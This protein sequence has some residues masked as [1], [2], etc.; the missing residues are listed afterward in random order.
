MNR[1]IYETHEVL[2]RR[3]GPSFEGWQAALVSAGENERFIWKRD[4]DPNA[5]E[6]LLPRGEFLRIVN[7]S[8]GW[9]ETLRINDR[10]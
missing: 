6:A 4:I 8:W 9:L 3:A 10:R 1:V 7:E 2:P 5:Q